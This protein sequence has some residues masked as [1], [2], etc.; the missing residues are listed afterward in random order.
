MWDQKAAILSS[1]NPPEEHPTIRLYNL[2]AYC[3]AAPFPGLSS[4]GRDTITLCW[5]LKLENFWVDPLCIIQDDEESWL[6]DSA[7]MGKIYA[8]SHLTIAAE[9]PASC[10][11]GFLGEQH[12]IGK[13]EW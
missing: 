9:E 1:S 12:A 11:L 3:M 8:N 6:Q 5:A 10:K 4:T 13:P 2:E 7:E